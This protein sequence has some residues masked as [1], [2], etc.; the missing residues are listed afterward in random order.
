MI[1]IHY[2]FADFAKKNNVDIFN[3]AQT[4]SYFQQK[5]ESYRNKYIGIKTNMVSN[6]KNEQEALSLI[7]AIEQDAVLSNQRSEFFKANY[8]DVGSAKGIR[9]A[10][11]AGETIAEEVQLFVEELRNV[12]NNIVTSLNLN[13]EELKTRIIQQYCDKR[14]VT[15]NTSAF[16]QAI[17]Q[18]FLTHEGIKRLGINAGG[19]GQK[20]LDSSLRNIILL[21][22]SLPEYGTSGNSTLGGKNYSTSSGPGRTKNGSETLDI[23]QRK[24]QGLLNNIQGIGA[25]IAWAKAEEIG[26]RQVGKEFIKANA[27]VV[28]GTVITDGKFLADQ[29]EKNDFHVSKPDVQVNIAGKKII[30]TYGVSVKQYKFNKKTGVGTISLVSNTSLLD[31]LE[32]YGK[33]NLYSIYNLAAGHASKKDGY[34]SESLNEMWNNLVKQVTMANFLDALIG[35]GDLSVLYLVVNGQ[36][37]PVSNI[38]TKISENDIVGRFVGEKVVSRNAFVKMNQWIGDD[39]EGTHKDNLAA[40]WRSAE[41]ESGIYAR[42]SQAKLDISLKNLLNFI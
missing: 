15:V 6:A 18:D 17:L 42:L 25:E 27:Q 30:I 22:E 36:V 26:E 35:L 13:L 10:A 40:L 37:I 23:I 24:L 29:Q 7:D 5:L 2:Y 12:I 34:S 32:K 19:T 38:L 28:G 33:Q 9:S 21:A 3:A 31:A 1:Y 16:R 14:N 39:R 8:K 4:T 41:A 11:A 20:A